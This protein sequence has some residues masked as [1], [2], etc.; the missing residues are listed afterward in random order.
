V[1]IPGAK[2]PDQ[3]VI[4]GNHHDAWVNGA[5][6]PVS[7]TNAEMEEARALS[8]L[9]K[10]GWKP[11]RTI[12]YCFWDGEEPGF[13][14]STEWAETHAEDLKQHAVAYINTDDNGRGYFGAQGSH[15][16]ENFVNDVI[17]DIQDPETNMSVWKR[18][19]QGQG[20]TQIPSRPPHRCPR[21]R[22]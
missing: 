6:D 2:H 19:R 12:I 13:L 18:T 22:F 17:K 14:G 10:Q 20:R 1:K 4:R 15:S 3:W 7:G 5:D 8:E 21:L 16:L 11:D 9:L